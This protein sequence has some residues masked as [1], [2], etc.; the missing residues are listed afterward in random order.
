MEI[1]RQA[2]EWLLAQGGI[3]G[4]IV[5]LAALVTFFIQLWYYMRVYGRIPSLRDKRR[6]NEG[7]PGGV[8]VIIPLRDTDYGFIEETLPLIL[9]Q[10]YEEMEVVLMDLADDSDF[11]FTLSMLSEHNPKIK[12]VKLTGAPMKKMSNKMLLNVGIKG[13]RY[14]NMV[15]TTSACRPVSERWIT[16]MARGFLRGDVVIG[17]CGLDARMKNGKGWARVERVAWSARWLGAALRGRAYRGTICNMGFTKRAYFDNNGFN[18]LN[19]NIGEDDLFVQKMMRN[20]KVSVVSAGKASVRQTIWGGW[21]KDKKLAGAT[22]PFYPFRV[23]AYIGSELW[24]RALFFASIVIML[25]IMPFQF[26]IG[27]AGL[28]V[29]RYVFV[30][31]EMSRVCRR[32]SEKGLGTIY[33]IYDLAAPIF[34]AWLA[35]ARRIRRPEGL[36]R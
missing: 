31:W 29:L 5:M 28:L 26:K 2:Y 23:R 30:A 20:S 4:L 6:E 8:S 32:L 17:Y 34:E 7:E 14:E 25:I 3:F 35:V 15:F 10:N 19:M 9:E 27:A 21:Y 16:A 11:S 18:H 13:A 33:F 24:S 1:F 22:F 12:I 36:W